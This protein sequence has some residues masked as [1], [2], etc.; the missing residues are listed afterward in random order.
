MATTTPREPEPFDG[1]PW[2]GDVLVPGLPEAFDEPHNARLRLA[3]GR[4]QVDTPDDSN[5]FYATCQAP[6]PSDSTQRITV[7]VRREVVDTLRDAQLWTVAAQLFGI[8]LEELENASHLFQGLTRPLFDG[9][10]V[11]ADQQVLI[12]VIRPDHDAIWQPAEGGFPMLG[13]PPHKR[14]FVVLV[15]PIPE[16]PSGIFGI[17]EH[18]N[19]VEEDPLRDGLP[20]SF[21]KRYTKKLWSR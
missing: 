15:K 6:A 9:D 14:V 21:G 10:D 5:S 2:S 7:A 12:Y 1:P 13:P 18:W 20:V 11:N 3:V 8:V 4:Q 19:W 16:N 17:A